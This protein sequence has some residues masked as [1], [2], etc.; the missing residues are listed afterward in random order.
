MR[1]VIVVQ[2]HGNIRDVNERQAW[3]WRNMAI[4]EDHVVILSVPDGIDLE[5]A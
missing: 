2:V 3:N 4:A 5:V 1:L